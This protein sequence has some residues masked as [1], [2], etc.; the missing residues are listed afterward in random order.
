MAF[1]VISC[2]FFLKESVNAAGS[3][4]S[5]K[6]SEFDIDTDEDEFRLKYKCKL[7]ISMNLSYATKWDTLSVSLTND[8]YA[9]NHDDDDD[10]DYDKEIVFEKTISGNKS[11]TKTL[12]LPAG[13]YSISIETDEDDDY[14]DEYDD[15]DD[16]DDYDESMEDED[17]QYSVTLSGK[18]IPI[19]SEKSITLQKGSSKTIKVK[20]ANSDSIIWKSSNPSIASVNNGVVTA[21]KPGKATITATLGN[22]TCK[23]QV[24]VTKKSPTY[25]TMSQKMKKLAK[26]NK[27]FTFKTINVG[28]HC[29]LYGEKIAGMSDQSL[30]YSAGY[31]SYFFDQP[32]I[33]L[34][35]KKNKTELSFRIN[36]ELNEVA[37][38]YLSSTPY[39]ELKL[40]TS[41]RRLN[42]KLKQTHNTNNYDYSSGLYKHKI[43]SVTV[44]S[45]SSAIES[46]KLKTIETML[47]Q[48]PF[49]LKMTTSNDYYSMSIDSAPRQNW[50]KLFKSYRSLLKNY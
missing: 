36:I 21:K 46:S 45:S 22:Y 48:N 19:M 4:F 24:T 32:Y 12:I 7:T 5:R 8:D 27:K 26:K 49:S 43:N 2:L 35:K 30:I 42:F 9:Y 3:D 31:F 44:L 10:Y 33:E 40:I 39:N 13:N 15:Y 34:V 41:N 29:R 1:I 17:C 11:Y 25:K 18:Y 28:K 16:Y 38:D 50:K 14:D 47:G 37:I 23:C 6:Y 20:T